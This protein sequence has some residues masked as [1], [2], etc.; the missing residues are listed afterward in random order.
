MV[1][2]F[3]PVILLVKLPVPLSLVVLLLLVVGFA[4]VPQH[5]PLAVTVPPPS[6]VILPPETA[7]VEVT[8]V[9][10]A[11]V[12]VATIIGL[13]VNDTSFPYPVPTLFVA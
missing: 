9:T 5:T 11:V 7:V 1:L 13:E 10:A 4:E 3:K 8:E 6:D 2:G 12:K